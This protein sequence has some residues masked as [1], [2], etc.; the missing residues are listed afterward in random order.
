MGI[1]M[2]HT[3]MDIGVRYPFALFMNII[4]FP[5][6]Q[7]V[8]LGKVTSNSRLETEA[9]LAGCSHCFEPSLSCAC[10]HFLLMQ[11]L[12]HG[13]V[14]SLAE[15]LVKSSSPLF[16]PL[17]MLNQCQIQCSQHLDRLIA[18]NSACTGLCSWLIL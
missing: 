15:Q 17:G 11:C 7:K 4:R 8:L 10:Q 12:Y 6:L 3:C 1:A 9:V 13:L 14:H 2:V 16:L 18:E 5:L